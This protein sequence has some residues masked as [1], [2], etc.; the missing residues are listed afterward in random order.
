MGHPNKL[1]MRLTTL[2]SESMVHMATTA[3]KQTR[4]LLRTLR[5][6][7]IEEGLVTLATDAEMDLQAISNAGK[8]C[9]GNVKMTATE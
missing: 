2:S 1:P 5:L 3:S 9:K 6:V 8:F 7:K 4:I